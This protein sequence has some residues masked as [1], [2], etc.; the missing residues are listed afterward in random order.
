[1]QKWYANVRTKKFEE[2]LLAQMHPVL[3]HSSFSLVFTMIRLLEQNLGLVIAYQP[4]A[5][6]RG[7]SDNM[8]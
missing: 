4:K 7:F 2:V 8:P 1:M 6:V 3:E 5:V